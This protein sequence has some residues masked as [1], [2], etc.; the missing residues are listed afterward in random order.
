MFGKR[1]MKPCSPS[2]EIGGELVLFIQIN[3]LE[4]LLPKLEFQK[5]IISR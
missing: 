2:K 5:S 1:I 3:Y 4:I